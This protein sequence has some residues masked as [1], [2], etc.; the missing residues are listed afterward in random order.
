V[1]NLVSSVLPLVAL[2]QLVD[3]LSAVASGVLRAQGRQG[4]GA[5]LN[6]G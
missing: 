5:L 4:V 6:L 3:G 1:I 2:N